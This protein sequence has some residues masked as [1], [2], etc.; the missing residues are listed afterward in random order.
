MATLFSG[1]RGPGKR[2]FPGR[3]DWLSPI[4]HVRPVKRIV[5]FSTSPTAV[6]RRNT[7]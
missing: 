7:G 5:E 3:V 2:C 4:A 6:P 1:R